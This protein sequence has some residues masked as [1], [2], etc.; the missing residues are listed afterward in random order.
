MRELL[1]NYG[2]IFEFWFDGANGGDGYYGGANEMRKI[3]NRTY[4]DWPNSHKIVRELQPGAIMFSDGGPDIRWVGNERG[5]A[6]ETNWSTVNEG[7][8]YPGIGGVNEQ[9]QS[10]HEDGNIWLPTEVNTSIRPGWFYHPEQNSLVKSL[11][12]LTDNWFHSVGMNGNFLLNIPPDTRGLFHEND[13]ARLIEFKEWRDKSFVNL[14]PEAEASA[15]N[16]RGTVY[17]AALATDGNKESFWSTEEGILEATIDLNFPTK[18]LN[19]VLIQEY[20][21][22]GQRVKAFSVEV[23]QEGEFVEVANGTTIGNRRIVRFPL[24]ETSQIRIHVEAKASPLIHTIEAY[25]TIKVD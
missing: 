19:A 7:A 13:V 11:H 8:F 18:E 24:V 2:E 3:D 15:T 5:Y 9:L 22:L 6:G 23:F 10:G 14:I 4:Y 21:A 12:Q 25:K 17:N 1:S 20:I 16:K